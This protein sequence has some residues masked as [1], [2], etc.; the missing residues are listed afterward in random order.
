MKATM[1]KLEMYCRLW[2][3]PTASMMLM[4]AMLVAE[5]RRSVRR[6]SFCY[7]LEQA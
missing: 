3:R 7:Q 5:V 1:A 2:S 6:P 4:N